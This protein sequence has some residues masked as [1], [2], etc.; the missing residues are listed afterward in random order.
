MHGERV[1]V[2]LMVQL[3]L[4]DYE[5][6]EIMELMEMGSAIGLPLCLN[7]LGV[8]N[9]EE[10]AYEM[11]GALQNDHFMVMLNCD[12]SVDVLAGA[13]ILANK[14]AEDVI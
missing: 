2:G 5:K 13:F 4:E 12:Y 14:L 1:F 7:D 6:E 10:T 8:Q 11:A 3:I 9:A